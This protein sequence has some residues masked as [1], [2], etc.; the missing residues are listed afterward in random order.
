[1]DLCLYRFWQSTLVCSLYL[2]L[3]LNRGSPCSSRLNRRTSLL[4]SKLT[5]VSTSTTKFN[6]YNSMNY[7]S[8]TLFVVDL[9]YNVFL[10]GYIGGP[11]MITPHRFEIWSCAAHNIDHKKGQVWPSMKKLFICDFH[12][13]KLYN[14]LLFCLYYCISSD[15]SLTMSVKTLDPKAYFLIKILPA[16]S[17]LFFPPTNTLF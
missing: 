12:Y 15:C 4:Q 8:L 5:N 7:C 13:T 6:Q 3:N 1:M 2:H 17:V 10:Y 16:K 11:C 9:L 14:K